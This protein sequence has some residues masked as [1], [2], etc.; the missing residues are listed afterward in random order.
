MK[1]PENLKYTE[2]NEWVL[3]EDS[4]AIVGITEFAQ[5]ALGDITYVSLPSLEDNIQQFGELGTVESVKA[6]CEIFAPVSGRVF[7]VNELLEEAPDLMNKDPYGNG[8]FVRLDNLSPEEL[9]SLM[10]AEEYAEFISNSNH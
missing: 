4:I 1:I 9:D 2:S 6:A 7:E 5:E 10:D 8:W 3:I